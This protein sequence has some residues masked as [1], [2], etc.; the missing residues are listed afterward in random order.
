MS[1]ESYSVKEVIAEFRQEMKERFDAVDEAQAHTNGDVKSLKLWKAFLTGGMTII[2]AMVI[3]LLI[4]V[5][6]QSKS[7]TDNIQAL[8]NSK[9][10]Y[11]QINN[12]N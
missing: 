5:W 6:G 10:S 8:I 11:A 7:N 12:N 9:Q 1:K 2:S 3:P 4:Y